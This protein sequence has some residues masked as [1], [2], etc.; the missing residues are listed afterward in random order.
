M[1]RSRRELSNEYLLAKFGFDTAENEPCKVCPLSAYRSPRCETS[2]QGKHEGVRCPGSGSDRARNRSVRW[3]RIAHRIDCSMLLCRVHVPHGAAPVDV[4]RPLKCDIR[5]ASWVA[6]KSFEISKFKF[7]ISES[8]NLRTSQGSFSAVSKPIFASKYSLE[9]SRRD[10]H[11][12]LLCTVLRSQ[13]FNQ[14]FANVLLF[15][16]RN[17]HIFCQN[18]AE[19]C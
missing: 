18:F 5:R 3:L 10:L 6:N 12:V 7:N 19:F 17:F 9:S 11:N 2:D 8:S 14:K 15:F 13:F 16:S 4:W 1:C